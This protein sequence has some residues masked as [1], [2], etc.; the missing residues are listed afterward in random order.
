LRTG[1][2]MTLVTSGVFERGLSNGSRDCYSN[3]L[4]LER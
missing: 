2:K 4:W 1:N 3:Q